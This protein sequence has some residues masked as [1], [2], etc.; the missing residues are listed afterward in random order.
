MYDNPADFDTDMAHIGEETGIS[1]MTKDIYGLQEQLM[2]KGVRFRK[3][4]E[5]RP[6][7]GVMAE[8]FDPDDN[9]Y[10]IMQEE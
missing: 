2:A 1:F 10:S 6:W 7:G 9:V 8:F 3:K 5:A 4:A